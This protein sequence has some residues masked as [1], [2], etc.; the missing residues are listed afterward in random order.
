MALFQC[1]M[2]LFNPLG[3]CRLQDLRKQHLISL[4]EVLG[5]FCQSVID[6]YYVMIR[7]LQIDMYDCETGLNIY[8]SKIRYDLS[9]FPILRKDGIP[10]KRIMLVLRSFLR[11]VLSGRTLQIN[12]CFNSESAE[13]KQLDIF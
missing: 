5:T 13:V 9:L 1:H 10:C 2:S 4:I 3:E 8:N 7:I 6:E 11:G 12:I